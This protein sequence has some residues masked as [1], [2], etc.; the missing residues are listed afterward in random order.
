MIFYTSDWHLGHLKLAQ[1][2]GFDTVEEHDELVIA[3]H[4]EVV[5]NDDDIVFV[6]GDIT[7]SSGN[8]PKVDR[9]N[10]RKILIAGNHDAVHPMHRDAWKHQDKWRQHFV[11]IQPWGRRIAAKIEF[12]MSHHPYVGDH[13]EEDRS[14]EFRLKNMGLPIVHGHVHKDERVTHAWDRPHLAAQI[15][16]GLDAWDLRPVPENILIDLL[17]EAS[18]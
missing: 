6:L 14:V 4:N 10:G 9:M 13:T 17:R 3:N 16:V 1:F 7:L 8:L 11:A 5:R 2:R 12:L 15:H 18:F